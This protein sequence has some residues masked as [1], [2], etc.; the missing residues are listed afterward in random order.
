MSA[1]ANVLFALAAA[2][3]LVHKVHHMPFSLRS[4]I[5]VALPTNL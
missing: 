1:S 3:V 4:A 5:Y 2:I